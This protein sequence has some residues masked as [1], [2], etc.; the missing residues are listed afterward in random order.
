M[1][2][3]VSSALL[4]LMTVVAPIAVSAQKIDNATAAVRAR[5]AARIAEVPGAEVAIAVQDLGSARSIAIDGDTL[6]HAASTMKVPVLFALFREFEQGRMRPAE[7]LRL[8]NHFFSIVDRSPYALNASDD[9]DSSVYALVGTEVP[10]KDLATRMI[11]HSSNLATNALI[12]RL[13]AVRITAITRELGATRMQ[14]LR[15]VEDNLAFGA[16]LNNTTTANDLVALFVALYRGKVA[17]PSSTRDMLAILEAQAFNDE[18][19]AGLPPGTRVAHKTGSI[20]ATL[21][22]AGLVYPPNRAPYAI[23]VLTRNIP[24]QKTAARLIADCSRIV[25]EWVV[26]SS[27]Q[28]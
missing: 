14:V 27:A 12:G 13:D 16:G 3:V 9:S 25:W 7:T 18:I 22:D 17:N 11:T 10:L 24:D 6:Y 26:T 28:R 2:L 1:A 4:S 8:E 19:P 21:H 20:T 15:G 5:L 23:A